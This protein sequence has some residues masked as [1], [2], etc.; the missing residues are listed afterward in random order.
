LT[1]GGRARDALVG[2]ALLVGGAWF[3][4]SLPWVVGR[5]DEG[6]VLYEAKMLLEGKV[7]Y[8]DMFEI[9]PPGAYYLLAGAF[10][11]FG[12]TV[13]TAKIVDALLQGAIVVAIFA[14]ARRLGVRAAVAAAAGLTHLA[15]FQPA[16]GYW[17]PHWLSSFLTLLLLGALLRPPTARAALAAG[18]VAGGIFWVQHQ[19]AVVTTAGVAAFFVLE[20]VLASRDRGAAL[21]PRLAAF[22]AG[23][24]LMVVPLVATLVATAGVAPVVRALLEHPL[25]RYAPFHYVPWGSTGWFPDIARYTAPT[26]LRWMPAL[27]PL[28]ALAAVTAYRRGAAEEGRRWMLLVAMALSVLATIAY[29]PDFVHVSFTGPVFALLAARLLES[30]LR[31]V[32]VAPAGAATAGAAVGLALTGLAVAL[33]WQMTRHWA[34]CAFTSDTAFGQVQLCERDEQA[35]VDG[36]IARVR[37]A[38]VREMFVYPAGAYLYLLT[39]TVNP[40]PCQIL[41]DRYSF[42]EQFDETLEILEHRRV[43]FV[44]AIPNLPAGDRIGAYLARNYLAVEDLPW[45]MR[46]YVR[47]AEDVDAGGIMGGASDAGSPLRTQPS[48]RVDRRRIYCGGPSARTTRAGTPAISTPGGNVPDTTECA[49]T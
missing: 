38:G 13:A 12:A 36:L 15:L 31:R 29:F 25:R 28:G 26:V 40:T 35:F 2:L 24:V 16:W 45:G 27:L 20:R 9:I 3:V 32:E 43:P 30:L 21:V 8:R 11:L 48:A 47:H 5:S 22:A 34:D 46:L 7:L 23:V 17:S 42:P 18:I 49:L 44:V 19:K 4:G 39:G 1:S 14:I 10:R 41:L 37:A 6:L 33:H